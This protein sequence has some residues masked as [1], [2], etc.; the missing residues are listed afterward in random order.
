MCMRSPSLGSSR[1]RAS[2]YQ[3]IRRGDKNCGDLQI[4]SAKGPCV[5]VRAACWCSR[6]SVSRLLCL[7]RPLPVRQP[8]PSV[9][10]YRLHS[11]S[12]LLS[13]RLRRR[14]PLRSPLLCSNKVRM[15]ADTH[16]H[17]HTLTHTRTHT[18]FPVPGFPNTQTPTHCSLSERPAGRKAI[19]DCLVHHRS[20]CVHGG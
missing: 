1:S 8:S 6:T 19:E 18:S 13:S 15:R 7:L 20:R 12:K 4:N 9:P 11:A 14:L 2:A 16:T 5:S 17:T 10:N 3:S